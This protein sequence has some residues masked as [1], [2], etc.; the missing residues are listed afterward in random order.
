MM[1]DTPRR[2]EKWARNGDGRSFWLAGWLA[3]G[4]QREGRR[5]REEC[6]KKGRGA[7]GGGAEG[8][9]CGDEC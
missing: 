8:K 5:K 3:G 2:Q 9:E 7:G 4:G 1:D 6:C